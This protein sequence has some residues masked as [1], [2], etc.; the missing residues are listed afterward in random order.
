MSMDI[1]FFPRH[2]TSDFRA[3]WG[4]AVLPAFHNSSGRFLVPFYT[5]DYVFPFELW[6]IFRVMCFCFLYLL[7]VN[8]PFSF[9]T[10]DYTLERRWFLTA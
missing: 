10:V 4:P 8:F 3:Y 6:V 1:S 2:Y 7:W 9:S 5:T